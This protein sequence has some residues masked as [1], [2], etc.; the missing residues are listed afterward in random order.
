M[1]VFC[2]VY[3]VIP[4][5]PAYLCFI[6]L[7]DPSLSLPPS[8]FI[9][10]L[11]RRA[12][13]YH[14]PLISLP[15][16]FAQHLPLSSPSASFHLSVDCCIAD[17]LRSFSPSHLPPV[18]WRGFISSPFV[19]LPPSFAQHLPLSSPSASSLFIGW[20]LRCSCVAQLLPISSP[21]GCMARLHIIPLSSRSLLPSHSISPSHLPPPLPHSLVDDCCVT[22]VLHGF[23]SFPHSSPSFLPH[24]FVDIEIHSL[25]LIKLKLM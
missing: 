12:T 19:S 14:S 21:S 10:W 3:R 18:A 20:L 5:P 9:C 25:F 16:S 17:V 13:S 11:L 6:S 1:V 2:T 4:L 22:V 15:P 23:I 7:P 8:S 24:S